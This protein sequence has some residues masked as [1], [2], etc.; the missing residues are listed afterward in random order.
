M[1]STV[2]AVA[3]DGDEFLMVWHPRRNGWASHVVIEKFIS[4]YGMDYRYETDKNPI[5]ELADRKTD[6]TTVG[7][8]CK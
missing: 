3:F 7:R 1:H 5:K 6:N 8:K 2:Y 4:K